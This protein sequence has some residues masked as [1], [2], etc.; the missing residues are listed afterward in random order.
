MGL[1]WIFWVGSLSALPPNQAPTNGQCVDSTVALSKVEPKTGEPRFL[2]ESDAE[3]IKWM[4]QVAEIFFRKL[5]AQSGIK[6]A[7][8][9][10]VAYS[11]LQDSWET[12]DPSKGSWKSFV[13]RESHFAMGDLLREI[14]PIPRV[15]RAR[16]KAVAKFRESHRRRFGENPSDQLIH[17]FLEKALLEE[18]LK[19]FGERHLKEH[20]RPPNDMEIQ[21]FLERRE[22]HLQRENAT[23]PATILAQIRAATSRSLDQPAGQVG[24]PEKAPGLVQT[25]GNPNA[26]SPDKDLAQRD[27]LEAALKSLS[28][29]ERSI[30]ILYYYASMTMKE[31]GRTLDI[32]ESRVSQIHSLILKRLKVHLINHSEI[33]LHPDEK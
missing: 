32:S 28:Q 23:T 2:T 11:R 12:F 14:D 20:G 16:E 31:I 7:E 18:A 19:G 6:V 24:G 15:I 13:M 4:N 5:P 1:V 22:V 8:L 30:V 33:H 17:Q 21:E 26:E 10:S 29:E 9:V 27:E 25:L 3:E